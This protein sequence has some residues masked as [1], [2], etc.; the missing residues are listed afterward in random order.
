M[1]KKDTNLQELGEQV[2]LIRDEQ[3]EISEVL[4]ILRNRN[5]RRFNDK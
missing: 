2:K 3:D 5:K 1:E 4:R